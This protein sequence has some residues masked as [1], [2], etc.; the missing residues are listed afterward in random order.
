MNSTINFFGLRALQNSNGRTLEI[1]GRLKSPDPSSFRQMPKLAE[2]ISAENHQFKVEDGVLYSSYLTHFIVCPRDCPGIF[3]VPPLVVT[4]C[5]YAFEGCFLLNEV[6]RGV[7][8]ET[9]EADVFSQTGLKSIVIPNSVTRIGNSCFEMCHSL[10]SITFTEGNELWAIPERTFSSTAISEM[11][12]PKR[13]S[14][15]GLRCFER[16]TQL[17]SVR[18]ENGLQLRSIRQEALWHSG[19]KFFDIPAVFTT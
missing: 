11:I 10:T 6:L 13:A 2:L 19:I 15:P 16:P 18:F 14:V 1:P 5:H 8:V 9:V 12:I 17:R 4:V 3:V 7:S